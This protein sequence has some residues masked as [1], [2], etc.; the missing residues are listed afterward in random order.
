MKGLELGTI[1][2]RRGSWTFR[3]YAPD[4]DGRRVQTE[5]TLCEISDEYRTKK[6]ALPKAK[7]EIERLNAP[8]SGASRSSIAGFVETVYLPFVDRMKRPATAN[9]YRKLWNGYL[10]AHFGKMRLSEYEPT[11]AAKF[12]DK[13][14]ERGLKPNTVHHVRSLMSAIFK[15][16]VRDGLV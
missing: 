2:Q 8:Q 6:D 3:Y 13:L 4:G 11:D 7:K 9:G 15:R 12:L 5:R 14:V 1:A 16:A 10:K